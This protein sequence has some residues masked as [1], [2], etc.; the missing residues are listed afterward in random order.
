MV[1]KARQAQEVFS[2]K[3]LKGAVK[4]FNVNFNG[5]LQHRAANCKKQ[6]ETLPIIRVGR[7]VNN[8][9]QVLHVRI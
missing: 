3:S 1:L 2:K 6:S 8:A 4:N 7:A 9:A 5:F